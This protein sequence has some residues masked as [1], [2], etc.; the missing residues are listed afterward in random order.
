MGIFSKKQ[1]SVVVNADY[2]KIMNRISDVASETK[3]LKAEVEALR[4]SINS[5]NGRINRN[6]TSEDKEEDI[7][8]EFPFRVS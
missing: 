5:I 2:E 1:D 3:V 7:K 6:K 8:G 4:S